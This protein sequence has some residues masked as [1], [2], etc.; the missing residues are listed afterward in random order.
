MNYSYEI[1]KAEPKHKFLSVRYFAE[2]RDDYFHN[3]NPESWESSALIELI[4]YHA[5]FAV[6]HWE[7]Q[8]T[9]SEISDL[10]VGTVGESS[11][12]SPADPAA[13]VEPSQAEVMRWQRDAML[14]ET[15]FYALPDTP[16]MSPEMAAYRQALRD[17]PAQEKFPE[18]VDWPEKPA[19]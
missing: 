9:V 3:F 12:T 7:Y 8:E 14:Q 1:L 18:V 19:T 4:E 16:E 2:G 6:A 15:D 13:S 10:P 11:A 17:V 5:Q